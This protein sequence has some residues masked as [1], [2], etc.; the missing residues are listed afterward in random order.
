MTCSKPNIVLVTGFE[1]FGGYDINSSAEA[2]QALE[3]ETI[4]GHTIA[5]AILPCVFGQSF[6]AL[7][8][9]IDQE[10]PA[11]ILCLGQAA[12]RDAV[13]LERI[14]INIDDAPMADNRGQKWQ[15]RAVVT[16]GPAAYWS[17][18]PLRKIAMALG[19]ADIGFG[20]TLSQS[21][22]TFVCNHLFYR[23][24]HSLAGQ[25]EVCGGFIHLPL[26]P[27]QAS[28]D[29]FGAEQATMPLDQMLAVLR[30]TIRACI[31]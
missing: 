8:K 28:S 9:I 21:A 24:M 31:L 19:A 13:S 6:D 29:P 26:L 16:D 5:S 4:A 11:L 27:I 12:G 30:V 15:D 2:A 1:P 22:G 23:L 7:A 10:Q 18:L 25:S 14:A 17:T 20:A 3:G